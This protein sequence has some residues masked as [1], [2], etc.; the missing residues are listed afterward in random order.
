MKRA[1]LAPEVIQVSQMD[2]GPSCLKSLLDAY[3][4]SVHYG[5]LREACQTDVDGTSIN[6]LEELACELG[7][8]AQ[9]VLVPFNQFEL[10]EAAITPC[11]LV[12]KLPN[13]LTHF[14]IV[15]RSL[16]PWVQIMDPSSGR[17]WIS[18]KKLIATAYH[19]RMPLEK[20]LWLNWASS[21]DFKQASQRR[22]RK[23]GIAESEITTQLQ[24]LQPESNQ[25]NN[26]DHWLV[27]AS[28]DAALTW[29]EALHQCKALNKG[30][31]L[32][33]FF[34]NQFSRAVQST[35]PWIDVI[36]R[37][38]WWAVQHK[39]EPDLL[40]V[41]ASVVVRIQGAKPA[42]A[43][44]E[45]NRSLSLAPGV[46]EAEPTPWQ[47]LIKMLL[48]G[49]KKWLIW[50]LPIIALAA[51]TV[52]TQALLFQG[53][54]GMSD[55]LGQTF[56]S[57]I[58]LVFLFIVLSCLIEFPI[59][60]ISL[61]LGRQIEN[62]F[63][64]A[65]FEKIPKI[66]DPYFR[67]RLL[68]DMARRS[69]KLY[70]L[71]NL[72]VFA[73]SILQQT[74]LIIFTLAGIFWLDTVSGLVASSLVLALLLC[75]SLLQKI[76][77]EFV[78][79]AETQS[80]VLNMLY[81]DSL[82]G[83]SVIRSHAA[84]QTFST[85]SEIQL[86]RWGDTQY[87]GQSKQAIALLIMDLLALLC[88]A[89]L[90]YSKTVST[91]ALAP[92]LLWFY[93]LLRLPFMVKYLN[94][95]LLQIPNYRLVVSQFA[96][97]LQATEVEDL[98][99]KHSG[100]ISP[101][102]TGAGVAIEFIDVAL[103]I[104]G[105]N[106]LQPINLSIKAGEHIAIVGESGAGKSS[107]CELLL[108]WHT[109]SSG[110][111]LIDKKPLDAQRLHLLRQQTAWVDANV[112]LWDRSLLDNINYD[113]GKGRLSEAGLGKLLGSLEN[114]LQTTLGA[115]G[116]R[117]SGGEGQRVRIARALGVDDARL[118]I[119]DEPCRGLD[120]VAREELLMQLR[121]Q[122][123]EATLICVTHDISEAIKFPRVVV[124]GEGKLLEQGEPK[125]LLAKSDSALNRLRECEVKLLNTLLHEQGWQSLR[126][127]KGQLQYAGLT[128][129]DTLRAQD[130]ATHV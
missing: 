98:S 2:C 33:T 20:D 9:Q 103:K 104:S 64:I 80:G 112:Q 34:S 66:H 18:W 128:T 119:L 68:T 4:I 16:G 97:L 87:R 42:E 100:F 108:G 48:P 82:K 67:T 83:L 58:P 10:P 30:Q 113:H 99:T 49:Q 114:G 76:L 86:R 32:L 41:E 117:L 95:L 127:Q 17:Q 59:A 84:Q 26:S 129:S 101:P 14:I 23:L 73:V 92:S 38:Y 8:D 96:E 124:I 40:I 46:T 7:L 75:S 31:E 89:V 121:N 79:R 19:H 123:A 15:W 57:F 52:T 91:E 102:E 43:K 65:L 61:S 60:A 54:L 27:I 21:D 69:H 115:D 29:A 47:V 77:Q 35:Q 70:R 36:P 51:A 78:S 120:R 109:P 130:E 126:M 12:T 105:H 88:I 81:F 93:W 111:L 71:R 106:L 45:T 28:F 3:R 74:A 25:E 5:R 94:S 107:L 50:L 24:K 11:I 72:P 44:A 55:L 1:W 56:N 110:Q 53:L 6:T 63:R 13:G 39:K 85:E 118:V 122:H 22:L 62:Q 37:Q 116:K 125:I 90:M